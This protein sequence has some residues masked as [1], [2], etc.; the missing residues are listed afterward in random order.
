MPRALLSLLINS[1]FSIIMLNMNRTLTLAAILAF[2]IPL[3]APR[4]EA[5][6]SFIPY[7]GYDFTLGDGAVFIGV[8]AEFGFLPAP[9]ALSFRPSAE[10]YFVENRDAFQINGELIASVVNL[11]AVRINAGAG[12]G[13]LFMSAP[14]TDSATEIGFNVLGGADF[15]SGF[16]VPF[17]Q[18]RLTTPGES[19]LQLMGGV[20]LRL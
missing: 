18:L 6:T 10:F 13:A 8:G 17:A 16:A 15:G 12:L 2:A 14:G 4:A 5:Q 19:R 1:H 11:P 7:A 9:L 3:L 20:K